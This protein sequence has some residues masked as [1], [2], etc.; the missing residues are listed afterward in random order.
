MKI[1]I[2]V[3]SK[4]TILPSSPTPADL[5]HYHL[6]YLDQIQPPIFMPLVM[7]YPSE[8]NTNGVEQAEKIKKSLSEA[9]TI[10]YPL[11][12]RIKVDNAYVDC[13]DEGLYFVEAKANCYLSD[14]LDRRDPG[15]NNSFIPFE[16]DDGADTLP[17]MVQITFFKC[18]GLAVLIGMSHKVGDASS[19]IMFLNCWAAI[20]RGANAEIIAPRFE[21][22]TLFPPKDISGFQ[23]RTG[24]IKENIVTKR[25]V[26]D[27]SAVANI[28]EKYTVDGGRSTRVEAL[29]AFIWSRFMAATKAETDEQSGKLYTV[30][31][32]VNLRTRMDP[33]L[34]NHYFG[35]ILRAVFTKPCAANEYGPHEI[36]N[37]IRDAIC[38]VNAEYVKK[39]QETDGH[40]EFMKKAAASYLKG[41]MVS[42]AFTS[43][44][45]FPVYETDFGW[46]K[47]VWVG[48]ARMTFKNLVTFF[49][50]KSGDGIEMWINLK[51]EDMAKF[52]ADEELIAYVSP[53]PNA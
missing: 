22:A 25:F 40:L 6:S 34:S 42:F 16:L 43:L 5:R 23:P 38:K 51:E 28:R 31:Q 37:Q 7:F 44:C 11:A 1:D 26:F 36:V 20:A 47:P 3:I 14:I 13:N 21:A 30:V 29:S 35:N 32:A 39:L 12:G 53:S 18:G 4:E 24:I 2:E 46:G 8:T 10:F 9:L 15:D 50:T 48:S 45:R 41:E 19:L 27:A 49:D 52:E 33:P 17:A